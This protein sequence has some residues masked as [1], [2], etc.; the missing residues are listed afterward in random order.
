MMFAK[1]GRKR[2][3][4]VLIA[5]GQREAVREVCGWVVGA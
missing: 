2:L 1:R 5:A 3:E 4:R